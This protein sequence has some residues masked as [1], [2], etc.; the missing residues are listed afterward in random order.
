MLSW[1]IVNHFDFTTQ[2]TSLV[3]AAVIY[4]AQV[5]HSHTYR[6]CC[7]SFLITIL[8]NSTYFQEP[9]EYASKNL[10]FLYWTIIVP[11]TKFFY[12]HLKNVHVLRKLYFFLSENYTYTSSITGPNYSYFYMIPF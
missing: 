9:P 5:F 3:K 7:V 12:N 8:I 10:S 6:K 1:R 11:K 2:Q 4:G